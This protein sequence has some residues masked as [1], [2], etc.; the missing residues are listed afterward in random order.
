LNKK[1]IIAEKGERLEQRLTCENWRE[2][3]VR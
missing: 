3:G 2:V 1:H